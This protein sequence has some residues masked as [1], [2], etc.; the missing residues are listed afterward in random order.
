MGPLTRSLFCQGLNALAIP[1]E[2]DEVRPVFEFQRRRLSEDPER[3]A[4]AKD[5]FPFRRVPAPV[6]FVIL[7][8]RNPAQLEALELIWQE[9]YTERIGAKKGDPRD[10]RNLPATGI[11]KELDSGRV[12][13]F[14]RL[15]REVEKL[16]TLKQCAAARRLVAAHRE[17][18]SRNDPDVGTDVEVEVLEVATNLPRELVRL[19]TDLAAPEE[20][21]G[22]VNLLSRRDAAIREEMRKDVWV[23]I[24]PDNFNHQL[25]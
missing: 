1:E 15:S 9:A 21:Q 22:F 3:R 24:H 5:L 16:E 6:K 19:F 10:P 23:S 7:A 2:F 18:L 14:E 25:P 20:I 4:G 13:L 17:A 12:D 11:R 8:A